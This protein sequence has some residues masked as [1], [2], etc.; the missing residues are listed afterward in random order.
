MIVVE[1]FSFCFAVSLLFNKIK[2][3]SDCNHSATPSECSLTNLSTDRHLLYIS[4]HD[5]SCSSDD[6]I[7][8]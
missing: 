2:G 5:C 3:D 6:N 7:T 1:L 4:S 8:D